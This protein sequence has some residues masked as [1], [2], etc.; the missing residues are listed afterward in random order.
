MAVLSRPLI[1]G[2]VAAV[3]PLALLFH[4]PSLSPL[5]RVGLGGCLFAAVYAGM[6]LGVM[7]QKAFY[8]DLFRGFRGRST[9]DEKALA[10]A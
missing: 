10:S 9:V 2:L 4:G 1:S 3:L 6:L 5:G 7:R 8:L